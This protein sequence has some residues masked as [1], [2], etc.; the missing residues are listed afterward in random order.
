MAQRIKEQIGTAPAVET[1]AHLI[2]VG[3]QMLGADLVPCSD[4]AAF[5]QRECRF[6]AVRM[7]V[8]SD[9]DVLFCAVVNS[10]ML[11]VP[12]RLAIGGQFI[13]HD[14]GNISADVL[15]DVSRQSSSLGI[16]GMEE[17]QITAA[18]ANPNHNLFVGCG[19]PA[20][21]ITLLSADIGFVQLDS[22][23]QHGTLY[24]SHRSTNPMEQIPCGFVGTFV[25]APNGSP[26]LM[27]THAF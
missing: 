16:F 10:F 24:C 27:G 22:T 20:S 2:Q 21:R 17:S 6:N 23:I 9:P 14:Y 12:D 8:C 26:Q 25:F 7:N 11:R 13:G 15:L 5:E 3:L 18:L 4:D 1:E 19:S